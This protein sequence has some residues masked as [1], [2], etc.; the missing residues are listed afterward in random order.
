MPEN[1][2]HS[3]DFALFYAGDQYQFKAWHLRGH[4]CH[5]LK[6]YFQ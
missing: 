4:H 3:S 6:F 1:P 2:L 5:D